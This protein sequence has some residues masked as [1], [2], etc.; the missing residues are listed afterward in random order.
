MARLAGFTGDG[1]RDLNDGAL[2]QRLEK[3]LRHLPLPLHAR[4]LP[5]SEWDHREQEHP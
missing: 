3:R 4:T 2:A 1:P 5:E